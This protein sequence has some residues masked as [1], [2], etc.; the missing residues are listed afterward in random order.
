MAV[1]VGA[2]ANALAAMILVNL[3]GKVSVAVFGA[4]FGMIIAQVAGVMAMAVGGGMM[5]GQ[6]LAT[7]WGNLMSAGNILTMTSSVGNGVAGYVQSSAMEWQAKTAALTNEYEKAAKSIQDQWIKEFGLGKF[8][9]DPMG[10][11]NNVGMNSVGETPSMFLDR[12]LMCGSDVAG[13]SLDMLSNFAKYTT[14]VS[15]IAS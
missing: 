7:S 5:S 3:L 8:A 10:L 13:M 11:T 15:T 6:T 4:K 1:I 2:V 9:F 12:T 14:D